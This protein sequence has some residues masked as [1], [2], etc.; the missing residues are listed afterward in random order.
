MDKFSEL[1]QYRNQLTK[2]KS[3]LVS[4]EEIE[5]KINVIKGLE[6]HDPRYYPL[7]DSIIKQYQQIISDS[8]KV[9]DNIDNLINVVEA[10]AD[11][12]AKKLFSREVQNEKFS[13]ENI[14][15]SLP[16]SREIRHEVAGHI[17]RYCDWKYPGL[18][19]HPRCRTWVKQMVALDPLYILHHDDVFAK[20]LIRRFPP[21]YQ[22][23]VR[24]YNDIEKLPIN[25]FSFI[26]LWDVLNYISFD[27]FTTWLAKLFELLRA[28]GTCMFS[29]NNCDIEGPARRAEFYAASYANVRLI[30]KLARDIGFEFIDNKDLE[31]RDAFNTHV[32]WI[33][34]QKPGRLKTVKAH[35]SLAK[36]VSK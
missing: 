22:N 6:N 20:K 23:R 14:Y 15:Q 36:I 8:N 28:G 30:I 25:Q 3:Q 24:L 17:D 32:S 18:I 26:L 27:Q 5:Q 2:S 19:M 9:I 7:L 34:L 13:L 21:Q 35:Q 1:I 4:V 10:D 12:C 31:T 33:E 16:M 29:Y 11:A